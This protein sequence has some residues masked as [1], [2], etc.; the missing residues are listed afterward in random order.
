MD[1]WVGV[2]VCCMVL[3]AGSVV[4]ANPQRMPF[5]ALQRAATLG[6][7]WTL[8]GSPTSGLDW[9]E[10]DLSYANLDGLNLR[11]A[12][13]RG[14]LLM[15]ASLVGA[16]LTGARLNGSQLDGADLRGALL[17]GAILRNASLRTADL[18]FVVFAGTKLHGADLSG[19]DLRS[20]N[21]SQMR[22][23]KRTRF[24][25]AV[26]GPTTL[27]P[28]KFE[29]LDAG[30]VAPEPS[31]TLLLGLGLVGLAICGRSA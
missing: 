27:F 9:A 19:A 25:S 28:G 5:D 6:D 23:N 4:W 16:D 22:W 30:M 3:F 18:R 8:A 2:G 24:E 15:H 26:F 11:Y 10:A 7:D 14:A 13:L 21:L 17:S 29:P 1:K 20:A 12:D 31:S